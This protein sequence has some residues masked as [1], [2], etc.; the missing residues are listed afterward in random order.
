MRDIIVLGLLI[1][2]FLSPIF[3]IPIVHSNNLNEEIIS[4]LWWLSPWGI[5][6]IGCGPSKNSKFNRG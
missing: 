4:L 2:W 6:F 5:I 3:W 1:L